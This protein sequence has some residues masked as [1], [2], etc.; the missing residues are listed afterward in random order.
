MGDH[1]T[2]DLRRPAPFASACRFTCDGL[3]HDASSA[4][5]PEARELGARG[6]ALAGSLI[7]GEKPGSRPHGL[8]P[9]LP[10][11]VE[12]EAENHIEEGEQHRRILETAR[13]RMNRVLVPLR[14]DQNSP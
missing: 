6:L 4:E 10:E 5:S 11:P 2:W 1:C 7:G 9:H 8:A 13:R 3:A 12:D 14:H